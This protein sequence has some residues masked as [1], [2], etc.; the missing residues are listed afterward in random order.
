MADLDYIAHYCQE[1]GR[2]HLLRDHLKKTAE[3]ARQF[4][5]PFH[6]GELAAVCGLIHDYGKY[7]TRF[8]RRIRGEKISF[9]HATPGGQ[10]IIRQ[11]KKN[12]MGKLAKA[13]AY[14]VMGH[15]GGLPDGGTERDNEGN[16]TLNSRLQIPFP[17]C[18][19]FLSECELPV[20]APPEISVA[21]GFGFAFFIR[22]LFSTLVD[23]DYLNTEEFFEKGKI[24][25]G[26][27]TGIDKL[28]Q[29]LL[30]YIQQN[31]LHADNTHNPLNAYRNALL[32]NCLDAAKEGSGLFTLTA[33]TGSGKTIASLTFALCHA[34]G[35]NKRRIIYIVPYNTIIEQNATVF[36]DILGA[37]NVLQHH[38]NIQYGSYDEDDDSVSYTDEER[39]K[40]FSVE[41]W[42]YPLIVT[43]NVQFF[44]SLF[45]AQ[46]GKCRKLHNI[47]DSVLVFDEAQ[48]IPLPYLRPC[49][50]AIQEL[51]QNYGCTAVLAT[52][53]Q[54]A[55]ES[56]FGSLSLKEISKDFREMY[57]LFRRVTIENLLSKP[58]SDE[59]LT[60]RMLEHK[61]A[62]CIVNTRK[63]AQRIYL[64]LKEMGCDGVFHLSTTMYAVHRRRILNEVRKRLDDPAKPPCLVI[65][66]SLI[67]AGVD[68]DFP[69]VY[70]EI[71]G[72]DSIIQAAG[73]CNRESKFPPEESP[74]FVFQ[75]EDSAV[76]QSQRANIDAFMQIAR[77]HKNLDAPET[78]QAYFQQ[79]FYN[80]GVSV[81]DEKAVLD[82]FNKGFQSFDFP[83]R[84][85]AEEFRLVE[86]NMQEIY[87]F[88]ERPD[89]ERRLR[90]GERSRRLFREMG[91]Y[92]VSLYGSDIKSLENLKQLE[93]LDEELLIMPKIFYDEGIGVNLMPKGGNAI[94]SD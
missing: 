19:V 31:Y 84:T 64:K 50:R 86:Q 18:S 82:R 14:C 21:D 87:I 88:Y 8:Q 77:M 43:S 6:G 76:P 60:S 81:L 37:E 17:D 94:F 42:D 29:D 24:L 89:I 34:A 56:Y 54:S 3:M 16:P 78:M 9:D 75:F 52:A 45:A 73:R 72:L 46:P 90:S 68:I 41:N 28:K 69:V 83:F 92:A 35:E 11:N 67:E 32:N 25:R 59:T 33:P 57:T 7:A 55:I 1:D 79:L 53:T 15:H 58:I 26:G 74:V 20:L 61:K 85:V 62:L 71:A 51:V 13:V 63:T 38:S 44:E 12:N 27:Y 93:R 48:M 2:Q 30:M 5:A 4:A 80:R 70:R 22:M 47:S 40:Q 91:Q 39:R 66:T 65:S 10:Y 36:E 49:I 23:A